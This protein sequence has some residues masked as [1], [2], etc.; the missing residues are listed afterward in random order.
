MRITGMA[1]LSDLARTI[2]EVE[3]IDEATVSLIARYVRE[4]G[5]IAT[6]G[7]GLSAAQMT[8]A[9]ATNLL[10]GVNATSVAA[11]A[12]Q[13]VR[14]YRRLHALDFRSRS[15]QRPQSSA[16]TLADAIE[17]LLTAT[18]RDEFPDQ[19]M[20]QGAGLGF[21]ENFARGNV[22]VELRFRRP[23]LQASL[24]M[25][26]LLDPEDMPEEPEHWVALRHPNMSVVFSPPLPKGLRKEI[27]KQSGDRIEETT[28]GYR[29]LRAVGKLVG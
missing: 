23:T 24:Q 1:N 25:T 12:P 29:T 11:S 9:D 15:D 22:H 27:T 26:E 13:A 17:Q 16:G 8:L 28:I 18:A 14:A 19:F 5:L 7:R 2:A 10:I 20:G 3:G 21:Q 6:Q 4:D